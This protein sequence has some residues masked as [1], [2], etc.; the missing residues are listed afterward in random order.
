LFFHLREE[1]VQFVNPDT[2][3]EVRG[4]PEPLRGLALVH[5]LD[6]YKAIRG[7]LRCESRRQI[8]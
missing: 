8:A 5:L 1:V 3:N 2:V 7:H 4:L 6:Q